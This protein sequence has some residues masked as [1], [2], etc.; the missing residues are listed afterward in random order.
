MKDRSKPK[1]GDIK[2]YKGIRMMYGP[3]PWAWNVSFNCWFNLD[4][5]EKEKSLGRPF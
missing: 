2:Y 3:D 5:F 1:I 4:L